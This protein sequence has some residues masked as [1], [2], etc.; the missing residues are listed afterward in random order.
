MDIDRSTLW[1]KLKNCGYN[2][3][4]KY[5]T[6]SPEEPNRK[7]TAIKEEHLL[8]GKKMDFVCNAVEYRIVSIQLISVITVLQCNNITLMCYK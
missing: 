4:E 2:F 1:R 3:K 7:I 6:I 8:I 5:S